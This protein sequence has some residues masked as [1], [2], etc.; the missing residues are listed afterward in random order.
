MFFKKNLKKSL[1]A[2]AILFGIISTTFMV[3]KDDKQ[4]RVI[5]GDDGLRFIDRAS[6]DTPGDG[7]DG[8]SPGDGDGDGG[9][10]SDA[11]SD[12][13]GDSSDEYT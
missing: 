6:A 1:Y 8:D 13:D 11:D 9:S 7:S 5:N 3:V 12:A 4:H 2:V 10:D